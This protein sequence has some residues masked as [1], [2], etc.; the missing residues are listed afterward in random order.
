MKK[1]LA[2]LMSLVMMVGLAACGGGSSD[3]GSA[4]AEGASAPAESATSESGTITVEDMKGTVEI[5]AD[6]QRVVDVS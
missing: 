5:P 3:S 1:V 2:I 6:P 4:A